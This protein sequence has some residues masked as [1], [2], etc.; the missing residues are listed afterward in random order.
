MR[1]IYQ[2]VMGRTYLEPVLATTQSALQ[3]RSVSIHPCIHTLVTK[4]PCKVAPA[5]QER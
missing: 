2:K 4:Q 5:H 1:T 3:H